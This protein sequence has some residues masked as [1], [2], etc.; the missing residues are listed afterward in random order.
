M[1]IAR[2]QLA[3]QTTRGSTLATELQTCRDDVMLKTAALGNAVAIIMKS[4]LTDC[5]GTYAIADH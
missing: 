1:T 3:A 2:A 4:L 5:H